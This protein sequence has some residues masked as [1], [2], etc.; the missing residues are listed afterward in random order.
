MKLK[1]HKKIWLTV[2]VA[3]V[4]LL[5]VGAAL[6]LTGKTSVPDEQPVTLV[7]QY[8]DEDVQVVLPQDEADRVRSILNHKTYYDPLTILSCGFDENVSFRIGSKTY[9]MACDDCDSVMELP[10]NRYFDI[11]EEGRAEIVEIF[12][13]YGGRFPCI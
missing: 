3:A 11:G 12:E 9:C 10:T 1:K 7:F 2:A 13:K 5:V 6:F 8:A 4:I